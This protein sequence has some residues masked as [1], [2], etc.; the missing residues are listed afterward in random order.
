MFR[1]YVESVW[2]PGR[3]LNVMNLLNSTAGCGNAAAAQAK[4]ESNNMFDDKNL[5]MDIVE[6]PKFITG[7]SSPYLADNNNFNYNL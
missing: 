1:L 6:P 2:Y 4:P 7:N 3:Q 5:F